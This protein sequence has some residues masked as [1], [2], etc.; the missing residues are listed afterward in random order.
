MLRIS[1]LTHLF[2]NEVIFIVSTKSFMK[3]S[4]QFIKPQYDV[5]SNGRLNRINSIQISLHLSFSFCLYKYSRQQIKSERSTKFQFKI[6]KGECPIPVQGTKAREKGMRLT[7]L[8]VEAIKP[9]V[10]TS[11]LGL[12]RSRKLTSSAVNNSSS[13]LRTLNQKLILN[14][15]IILFMISRDSK[16]HAFQCNKDL[17]VYKK[18][19]STVQFRTCLVNDGVTAL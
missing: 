9:C 2:S 8:T 16:T 1:R 18:S 6:A 13:C 4:L 12:T 19:Y 5:V 10:E 17:Y 14:L 3:S 11:R 7:R 15:P